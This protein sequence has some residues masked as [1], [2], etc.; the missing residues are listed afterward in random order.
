MFSRFFWATDTPSGDPTSIDVPFL[1]RKK[2]PSED[3]A[4][5]SLQ[6]QITM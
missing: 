2:D 6:L 4:T 1:T 5:V 3:W